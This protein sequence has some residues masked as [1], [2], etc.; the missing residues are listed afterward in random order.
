LI[1]RTL[2]RLLVVVLVA[3]PVGV[4][5]APIAGAGTACA[6]MELGQFRFRVCFPTDIV[7]GR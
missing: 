3:V 2:L 4:G 7:N 1:K 6:W 5:V